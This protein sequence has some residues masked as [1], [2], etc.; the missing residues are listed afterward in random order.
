VIPNGLTFVPDQCEDCGVTFQRAK[1]DTNAHRCQACEQIYQL[2][3]IADV[4]E[5]YVGSL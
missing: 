2:R 5:Y 3:R 1:Y 4:L